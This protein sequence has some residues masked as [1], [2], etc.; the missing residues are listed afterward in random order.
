M[1]IKDFHLHTKHLLEPVHIRKY[2][3]QRVGCDASCWLHRGSCPSALELF[4]GNRQKL[5]NI[6]A[7][8]ELLPK[9]S[10]FLKLFLCFMN[11]PGRAPWRDRGYDPPWVD[12]TLKMVFTLKNFG[13]IPVVSMK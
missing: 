7:T 11:I 5:K 12:F 1:G 4:H 10:A 2:Q 9:A 8:L 6:A 3:G 13:V